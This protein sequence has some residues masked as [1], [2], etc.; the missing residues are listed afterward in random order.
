MQ[1]A[2]ATSILKVYENYNATL[3]G[4]RSLGFGASVDEETVFSNWTDRRERGL[5]ARRPMLIGNC[6][7]DYASLFMPYNGSAP[8]QTAVDELTDSYFNCR[9]AIASQY[10]LSKCFQPLADE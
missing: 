9:A 4:G 10:A 3:N 2:N 5:V 6:D 1:K 8:N 7:N